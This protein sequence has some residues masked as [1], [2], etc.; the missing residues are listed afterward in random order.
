MYNY[1]THQYLHSPEHFRVKGGHSDTEWY[2]LFQGTPTPRLL[3][4]QVTQIHFL[5]THALIRVLHKTW[6]YVG[7]LFYFFKKKNTAYI[8]LYIVTH[9]LNTNLYLISSLSCGSLYCIV[10]LILVKRQLTTLHYRHY[11]HST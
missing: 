2:H 10:D 3:G 11:T 1:V 8:V 6:I 5:G 9:T 7:M 4:Q